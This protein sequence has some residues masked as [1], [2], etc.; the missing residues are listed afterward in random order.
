[1]YR[2][3]DGVRQRDKR[4]RFRTNLAAFIGA[5]ISYTS[6]GFVNFDQRIFERVKQKRDIIVV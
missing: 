2:S 3:L 5:T 6:C 1:M 4:L